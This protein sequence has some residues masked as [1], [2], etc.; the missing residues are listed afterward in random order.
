M[1]SSQVRAPVVAFA[2]SANALALPAPAAMGPTPAKSS[3]VETSSGGMEAWA[4]A[5]PSTESKAPRDITMFVT[6]VCP[7][8]QAYWVVRRVIIASARLSECHVWVFKVVVARECSTAGDVG[9]M[10]VNHVAAVPIGSPVACECSTAGDVG[11]MVV[12]H[13][14]AVPIG[15][16]MVIA[17]IKS[18]KGPD[19]DTQAKTAPP[20][21]SRTGPA[22]RS[23][24]DRPGLV[25]HTRAAG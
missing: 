17:P 18:R 1:A 8:T 9:L 11:P 13:V 21:R 10:V 2:H 22:P 19:P 14:A 25:L 23:S 15:S 24:P 3:T 5:R 12:N 4:E 20:V 7:V 16:P 6:T